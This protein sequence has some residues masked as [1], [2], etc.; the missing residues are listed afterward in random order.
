MIT[1]IYSVCLFVCVVML[2]NMAQKNY[3]NIDI[4]HWTILILIPVIIMAYWLKTMVTSPDAAYALIC[5]QYLD[6]A[7]LSVVVIFYL[8]HTAGVTARPWMK[9]ALYGLGIVHM[10]IVCVCIHTDLYYSKVEV[11]E[12]SRGNIVHVS[13]GPLMVY[14]YIYL[15]IIAACLAAV[16]VIGIRKIGRASCRERVFRAV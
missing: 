3:N 4:Y 6:S 16:V 2:L 9:I 13:G 8:L 15:A 11:I 10:V 1:V 14:H 5:F 7:F 12:S